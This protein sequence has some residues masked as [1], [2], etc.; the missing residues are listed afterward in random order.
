[1]K[2]AGLTLLAPIAWGTT[3]VLVTEVLPPGRPVFDAAARVLPAGVLLTAVVWARRGRPTGAALRR[4]AVL[5]TVNVGVFFPLLILAATLLPG[6]VAAAAGG[7]QPLLVVG[8]SALLTGRSVRGREIVV[9]V[10]A[11]LGVALVVL[12]PGAGYDVVGLLAALGANVSFAAGVVL[13]RRYP[14]PADPVG[15]VGAQLL[16]GA[17]LLV[18]LALVLEGPPPPLDTAELLGIAYFSLVATAAAF[19]VWFHGIRRLPV[20]APP[21][22]GLAAPLTG[23]ALGWALLGEELTAVQ[24]AGFALAF[25]A[26]GYGALAGRPLP[27]PVGRR[28]REPCPC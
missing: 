9:G 20:V 8:F 15:D 5:G 2:T 24:L 3:Y 22:L 7:L 21:L 26:I 1:M 13:T 17:V 25:A 18:P 12:R 19:V 28:D 27:A 4:A 16:A 6:G 10:V 23:A 11:A 14:P